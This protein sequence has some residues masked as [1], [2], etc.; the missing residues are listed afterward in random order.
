MGISAE[1]IDASSFRVS[2]DQTS[3]FQVGRKIKASLESGFQYS[4]IIGSSYSGTYTI[5]TIRN[6]VLDSSLYDVQ[7]MGD[8]GNW[9]PE[10][11]RSAKLILPR[12]T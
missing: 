11:W 1:Y 7:Y 3:E 8:G 5:V 9:V 10:S 12:M 2:G 6:P 4:I